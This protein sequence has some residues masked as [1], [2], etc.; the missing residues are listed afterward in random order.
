[1]KK[2]RLISLL[3]LLSIASAPAFARGAIEGKLGLGSVK[4][5]SN[6]AGF[7]A[8]LAYAIRLERF[9]AIVPEF[10]FNWLSYDNAPGGVGTT[11]GVAGSTQ[12]I[13]SNFYTFPVLLNGRLYIPMGSDDTPY[14]QPIINVGA[15]Y[16]WSEFSYTQGNTTGKASFSGFMYQASI[17]VLVNLGMIADGSASSTNLMLEAGYRGGSLGS[18]GVNY[19]WG[20]YLIR[21]GVN[22]AL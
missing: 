11:G 3:A 16:G 21:A 18:G 22:F 20:G 15:G 7:D 10:N 14:V 13:S 6:K 4:A 17:G 19:D 9:F 5:A 8:G 2:M 1:M 12:S